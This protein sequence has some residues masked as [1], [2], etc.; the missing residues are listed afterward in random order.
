MVKV[1][2]LT[3]AFAVVFAVVVETAVAVDP[4]PSA[5]LLANVTELPRPSAK[6]SVTET[7]A[8]LPKAALLV[9]VAWAAGPAAIALVPE[10]LEPARAE[11]AL[12]Y[13]L[14]WVSSAVNAE[15]TLLNVP[16]ANE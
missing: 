13:L 2:P 9:P 6:P 8:P 10:A 7:L 5:T 14:P 12:K 3:T 16:A 11:L 4:A 15:P 1:L